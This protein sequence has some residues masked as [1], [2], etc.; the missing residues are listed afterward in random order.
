M[1]KR[2]AL[3]IAPLCIW[4]TSLLA[5]DVPVGVVVAFKK[6]S[7][8]D[9]SRYLSDKVDLML[10]SQNISTDRDATLH[11][12]TDFFS[13][14]KVHGFNVNHQGKRNDSSFVIGTLATANGD[15][16]VNCFFRREQNK[17]IVH[18]IRIDKA[19]E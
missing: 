17:Y 13:H 14:N 6:G 1:R 19:N 12:L 9:L 5:Q 18:Q 2:I 10:D 4:A 15:F 7:S 8:Q 16:R 3:F 11:A